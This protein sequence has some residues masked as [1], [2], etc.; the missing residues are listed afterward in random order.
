MNCLYRKLNA[1][2]RNPLWPGGPADSQTWN[3][4]LLRQT[5]NFATAAASTSVAYPASWGAHNA[6]GIWGYQYIWKPYVMPAMNWRTTPVSDDAYN[7]GL[8]GAY[9]YNRHPADALKWCNQCDGK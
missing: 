6:A 5:E 1:D 7:A 3:D 8:A 9:F 4:P 2:R